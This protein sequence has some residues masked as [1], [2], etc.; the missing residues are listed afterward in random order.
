MLLRCVEVDGDKVLFIQGTIECYR[1]WQQ[2]LFVFVPIIILYPFLLMY[3]THRLRHSKDSPIANAVRQLLSA[4]FRAQCD[5]WG[6]MLLLRRIVFTMIYSFT[7]DPTWRIW[8]IFVV[9]VAV[10]VSNLVWR[11][12][13]SGMVQAFDSTLLVFHCVLGGCSLVQSVYETLGLPERQVVQT[14][15]TMTVV[16]AFLPACVVG[17]NFIAVIVMEKAL[18]KVKTRPSAMLV[19]QSLSN[20]NHSS[21]G[22]VTVDVEPGAKCAVCQKIVENHAMWQKGVGIAHAGCL[23]EPSADEGVC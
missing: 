19:R 9:C 1:P 4:P 18:K 11:P 12:H 20:R 10:L 8:A 21:G 5:W 6:G 3:L 7:T 23:E 15:A 14:F 22:G 2:A 16:L 13:K 17:A